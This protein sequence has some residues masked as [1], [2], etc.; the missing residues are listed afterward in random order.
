M[1]SNFRECCWL[2]PNFLGKKSWKAWDKPAEY[3][4]LCSQNADKLLWGLLPKKVATWNNLDLLPTKVGIVCVKFWAANNWPNFQATMPYI[5]KCSGQHY[6]RIL[7]LTAP[8]TKFWPKSWKIPI[9][10]QL[11]PQ[12]NLIREADDSRILTWN[13]SRFSY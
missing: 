7:L 2:K 9:I 10:L 5:I 12:Q 4:V 11:F 3:T 6:L 1:E 13:S 8:L